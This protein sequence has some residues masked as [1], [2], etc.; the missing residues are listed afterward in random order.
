[1]GIL[2]QQ[3]WHMYYALQTFPT[4]LL[5]TYMVRCIVIMK[6]YHCPLADILE[7]LL[8]SGL[9][10]TYQCTGTNHTF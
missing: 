5:H 1:M 6:A 2:P 10:K 3:M 7:T 9:L 4:L 8:F